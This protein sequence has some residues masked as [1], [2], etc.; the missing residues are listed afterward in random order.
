M[1]VYLSYKT[2]F[3]FLYSQKIQGPPPPPHTIGFNTRHF[4]FIH[5]SVK[6]IHYVHNMIIYTV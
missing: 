2:I 1:C 4:T 6:L 5:S 3:T